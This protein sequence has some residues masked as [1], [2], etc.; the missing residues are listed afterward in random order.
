LR[1]PGVPQAAFCGLFPVSVCVTVTKKQE[2]IGLLFTL[3][4]IQS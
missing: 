3:Y 4:R 2:I 1:V